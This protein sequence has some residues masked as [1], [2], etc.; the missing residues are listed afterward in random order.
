MRVDAIPQLSRFKEL[1]VR[2]FIIIQIEHSFL[3]SFSDSDRILLQ[4]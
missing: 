3:C 2:I 1:Q 4:I